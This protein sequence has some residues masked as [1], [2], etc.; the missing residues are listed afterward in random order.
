MATPPPAPDAAPATP[1]AD[2]DALTR[3]RVSIERVSTGEFDARAAEANQANQTNQ[4]HVLRLPTDSSIDVAALAA[5]LV[6]E[7]PGVSVTVR[8]DTQESHDARRRD[9]FDRLAHGENLRAFHH[10]K[11]S[12]AFAE[13]VQYAAWLEVLSRS[14]N[15][16]TKTV[17]LHFPLICGAYDQYRDEVLCGKQTSAKW[18]ATHPEVT[19]PE[20]HFLP[21]LAEAKR[22]ADELNRISDERHARNG[23]TSDRP[24]WMEGY[25]RVMLIRNATDE[26]ELQPGAALPLDL[27]SDLAEPLVFSDKTRFRV[28]VQGLRGTTGER[29]VSQ[30]HTGAEL[31]KAMLADFASRKKEIAD[32]RRAASEDKELFVQARNPLRMGPYFAFKRNLSSADFETPHPPLASFHVG[33]TSANRKTRALALTGVQLCIRHVHPHPASDE[34]ETCALCL[35]PIVGE[36]AWQCGA[37]HNRQHVD[38]IAE[39]KAFQRDGAAATCPCCR[40]PVP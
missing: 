22:G 7:H 24:A 26:A 40:A 6:E 31:R 12:R 36:G 25:P 18:W 14:G 4:A 23:M 27:Q 5:R 21:T 32:A 16:V 20:F 30:V 10:V 13:K 29:H 33:W 35:D 8:G 34:G 39:W 1:A 37:C 2:A 19:V 3:I 28:R 38:C 17:P 11:S 15:S 9:I